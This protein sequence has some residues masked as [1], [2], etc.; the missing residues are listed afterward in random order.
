MGKHQACN[1]VDVGSTP[2]SSIAES[3]VKAVE[4]LVC[5]TSNNGFKSHQTPFSEDTAEGTATRLENGSKLTL[6]G[7]IPLSSLI[8]LC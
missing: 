8:F 5:D 7:S 6:G 1:W 4:T 2:I 3:E